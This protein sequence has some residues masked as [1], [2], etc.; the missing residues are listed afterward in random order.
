MI[1]YRKNTTA[2]LGAVFSIF[3]LFIIFMNTQK[4]NKTKIQHY[5]FPEYRVT[6]TVSNVQYYSFPEKVIT[7]NR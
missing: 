5:T 2:C 4:I 6:G 1:T 3:A 7:V